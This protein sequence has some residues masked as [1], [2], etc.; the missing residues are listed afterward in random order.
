MSF[1]VP[2][3]AAWEVSGDDEGGWHLL[4]VLEQ[5]EPVL[6]TCIDFKRERDARDFTRWMALDAPQL[7]IERSERTKLP[8]EEE[9][10]RIA[11]Y[12]EINRKQTM[13]DELRA[14][15]LHPDFTQVMADQEERD[16]WEDALLAIADG[17]CD[18]GRTEHT[19]CI[20]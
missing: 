1:T 7:A 20:D 3:H 9:A 4:L 12:A 18:C 13:R 19:S 10:E 8:S 14:E 11:E 5:D 16:S 17:R 15:L 6:E 2:Q